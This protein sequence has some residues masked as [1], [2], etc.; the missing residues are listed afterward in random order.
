MSISELSRASKVSLVIGAMLF[1]MIA[2]YNIFAVSSELWF[3]PAF[4]IE[5]A[6]RINQG[7]QI[8][9]GAHDVHFPL[10]YYTL[11]GWMKLNPGLTEFNWARELSVFFGLIFLVSAGYFIFSVFGW[12]NGIPAFTFLSVGA[13]TL[14][15]F[16]IEPRSYMALFAMMAYSLVMIKLHVETKDKFYLGLA[17]IAMATFPMW[18]YF[19]VMAW[20]FVLLIW[21]VFEK[22]RGITIKQFVKKTIP[23][24]AVLA[25]FLILVMFV[26][27]PQRMRS[28]G[29]WFQPPSASSFPSAM[30]YSA[31]LVDSMV[32]ENS[33]ILSVIYYL[34][35]VFAMYCGYLLYQRLKKFPGT[36][37]NILAI[38]YMTCVIPLLA[39]LLLSLCSGGFCNL[40]H[41]RFFLVITWMFPVAC[42]TVFIMSRYDYREWAAIVFG[43]I[44]VSGFA[45]YAYSSGV[46]KEL[47]NTIAATPCTTALIGHESPFSMLPYKVAQRELGCDWTHFVSTGISERRARTSGFDV[48]DSNEIYWNNSLPVQDFYYV[49]SD[50]A[51]FYRNFDYL[52]RSK[53]LVYQ[54]DGIALVSVG[55]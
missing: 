45:M 40:Y 48:L 28:E 16:T 27:I 54:D 11:A 5:T 19:A 8:F 3:D 35:V 38:M 21:F 26:A 20:P 36:Q 53:T 7:D 55:P 23:V 13:T 17:T 50:E 41:H 39:L 25:I 29:T 15:Y 44:V 51:S 2:Q 9:W 24:I 33:L 49:Q 14:Q 30:F 31:F 46:H 37:T 47:D 34:F 10:Y 52:N 12:K 22:E 18:H 43:V 6:H 32:V 4:S 42:L 1:F